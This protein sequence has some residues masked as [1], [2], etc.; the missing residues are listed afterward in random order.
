MKYVLDT[1]SHTIASGH[2]YSTMMEMVDAAFEAGL[3]LL[4][5]T[6]HGAGMPGSCSEIYFQNLRV[7]RRNR[8]GM[9]LLLGAE[10]NILDYEGNLDMH[11][12][13]WKGLDIVIASLHMPCIKPVTK[14]QNT[15]ALIGAMKNPYVTII[16]HPDDARYPV[17]YE[18]LVLAAK[19]HHVLLELNNSS[20]NP[21]GFRQNARDND[22]LMLKLCERYQVPIV[23]GSDSHVADDVGNFSF[24]ADLLVELKFP[25]HLIINTSVDKLTQYLNTPVY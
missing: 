6:E 13:T 12:G 24:A 11:E 8:K 3:E 1:H 9:K 10:L 23:M 5:I 7:V 25:E 22:I 4:A 14:E 2:A 19:E 20:L 17:D 21:L 15:N 18:Q 16:G